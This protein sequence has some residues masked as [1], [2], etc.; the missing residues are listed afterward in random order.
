[1][2]DKN[3]SFQRK[4]ES[5]RERVKKKK[6]CFQRAHS[7]WSYPNSRFFVFWSLSTYIFNGWK[8]KKMNNKIYVAFNSTWFVFNQSKCN[9]DSNTNY[10]QPNR[11]IKSKKWTTLQQQQQV[12]LAKIDKSLPIACCA[13]NQRKDAFKVFTKCLKV[14]NLSRSQ[15]WYFSIFFC[16]STNKNKIK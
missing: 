2:R 16:A 12:D 5:E 11:S 14:W 6:I 1:M 7:T 9:I 10:Q 3:S 15:F 8:G 4:R 13:H